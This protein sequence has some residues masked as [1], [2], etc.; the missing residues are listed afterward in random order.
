MDWLREYWPFLLPPLIILPGLGDFAFPG[1]A[2]EYSDIVLTHYPNAVFLKRSLLGE[3]ILPLWSPNILSGYPFIAHPHSGIWYPPMWLALLL[4]LPLG[5]NLMVAAHL[6]IAG[7]AL[8]AFLRLKGLSRHAAILGGLA[9]EATPK[10]FAHFGAG[11]ILLV[12]AVCLTPLLFWASVRPSNKTEIWSRLFQPGPILALIFFLDPRWA[13]YS[14]VVWAIWRISHSHNGYVIAT[15]L[16]ALKQLLLTALIVLP[17]L[18]AFL[19]FTSLSTRSN[20]SPSEV[21]ALSLPVEALL[22]FVIPQWGVT[23]EWLLYPGILVLA[24]TIISI[25]TKESRAKVWFWLILVLV[26]VAL[27]LGENLPGLEALANLPGF[28]LLRVPTRALFLSLLGMAMLTA[29]GFDTLREHIS[30][31]GLRPVRLTLLVLMAFLALLAIMLFVQREGSW[32]P[33]LWASLSLA[34]LWFVIEKKAESQISPRSFIIA[35]TS[36]MLIDIALIASSIISFRPVEQVLSEDDEMT[37]FLSAQE[38]RFRVYSP[39]Y[40]LG[41]QS[42]VLNQIEQADGVDPIQLQSYA[43]F[44]AEASGVPSEGYTSTQPPFASGNPSSANRSYL[45]NAARLGLINVAFLLSEFPLESEDLELREMLDGTFVYAN[46]LVKAR[47]WLQAPDG[48]ENAAEIVDWAPNRISVRAKG[49]GTLVLSEIDYLGWRVWIDEEEGEIE[50]YADIL[51]SVD[52]DAG[53]HTVDFRFLPK[54]V[55]W[56]LPI[57]IGTIILLVLGP[58]KKKRNS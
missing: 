28:S 2:A 35:V 11:Q 57:S 39:S 36:L 45:P 8:Y 41:Q 43:D 38:G 53:V 50:T 55:I 3:G 17:L 56:G 10:I 4:P 25:V 40:S 51:R 14:G 9:F 19:E 16:S 52:L 47:A 1:K 23:H 42:A 49:P 58:S 6:I 34:T 7:A 48:S 12:S 22:G 31:K 32:Q 13:F 21:L 37:R 26:A 44:F 27:S 54:S 18:W 29:Y 20:L 30:I 24:F 33:A 46:E 15:S 5:L